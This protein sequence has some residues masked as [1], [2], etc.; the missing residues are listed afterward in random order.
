MAIAPEETR[1]SELCEEIIRAA[2]SMVTARRPQDF[3]KA[4]AFLLQASE[5][6]DILR[7]SRTSVPSRLA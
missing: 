1:E 4:Q 2:L 6:L 7:L 3:L 5:E